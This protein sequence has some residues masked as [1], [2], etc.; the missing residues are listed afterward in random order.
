MV[1]QF[2]EDDKTDV[3]ILSVTACCV[4]INLTRA[5]VA[6]FAELHW[7]AGSVMQAED[8]IHRIGQK[9]ASVRIIYL[10]AKGTADDIIWETIQKKY[11]VLGATVGISDNV[12]AGGM[13]CEK[14]STSSSSGKSA[15]LSQ[16]TMDGYLSP[17]KNQGLES[18]DQVPYNPFR[19]SY[20]PSLSATHSLRRDA[21]SVYGMPPMVNRSLPSSIPPPQLQHQ[22]DFPSYMPSSQPSIYPTQASKISSLPPTDLLP[23]QSNSNLSSS[24]NQT[25]NLSSCLYP[26]TARDWNAY[27][28]GSISILPNPHSIPNLDP[29]SSHTNNY[30]EEQL[31]PAHPPQQ[32]QQKLLFQSSDINPYGQKYTA[33][34]LNLPEPLDSIPALP[35]AH[36]YSNLSTTSSTVPPYAPNHLNTV[37]V[38]VGPYSS[39]I[40]SHST[41]APLYISSATATHSH[42]KISTISTGGYQSQSEELQ[43]GRVTGVDAAL[44]DSKSISRESVYN[45]YDSSQSQPVDPAPIKSSNSEYRFPLKSTSENTMRNTSD[46]SAH[47]TKSIGPKQDHPP[48]NLIH[49]SDRNAAV[50]VYANGNSSKACHNSL[51]HYSESSSCLN[52]NSNNNSNSNNNNNNNNNN[53]NNHNNNNNNHNHNNNNNNNNNSH[54]NLRLQI[55]PSP[56]TT[57]RLTCAR[58]Q[59]RNAMALQFHRLYDDTFT[60]NSL[61]IVS[62]VGVFA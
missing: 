19:D 51:D 31:Y 55:R 38:P 47:I 60:T 32:Q 4:G 59:Q 62:C 20:G 50:N 27:A 56:A 34:V 8:R 39:K 14:K 3:A 33:P 48:I 37:P 18:V 57:R 25:E 61:Q 30:Y 40:I 46:S 13:K 54:T 5:N 53:S 28:S 58:K 22:L 7:S 44:S 17:K 35:F 29:K 36:V 2:Q 9:A 43:F 23:Y 10:I 45:V 52:N 11:N 6:V 16:S 41:P 12:G 21:A 42:S 1:L 15:S 26:N 49:E 24:M